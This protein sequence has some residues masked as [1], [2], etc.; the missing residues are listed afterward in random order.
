MTAINPTSADFFEEKYRTNPDPWNF[1][2]STYEK[3]RYQSILKLLGSENYRYAFEPG[4][5]IGIL[6]HEL[7]SRCLYVEA[8]DFSKTAIEQARAYCGDL[9][10]VTIYQAS[11]INYLPKKA[12]DLIILSEI[13]YYFTSEDWHSILQG[14]L[15]CCSKSST[16]IAC[17]WLG[18]SND[19]LLSGDAV[20]QVL[21][22]QKPLLLKTRLR[23]DEFRL[24]RWSVE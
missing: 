21:D 19:H 16:I 4:C 8:I 18:Q 23:F 14:M 20:H 5:S 1:S 15:A 11:L 9:S 24:D 13:G 3:H 2:Q 7:A 22:Q 10:N 12:P 6:T 17:H